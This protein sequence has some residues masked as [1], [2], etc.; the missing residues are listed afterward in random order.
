LRHAE[1]NAGEH[2]GDTVV[3]QRVG[4]RRLLGGAGMAA[5]LRDGESS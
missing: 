5:G 2:V 4:R 3:Q 1:R